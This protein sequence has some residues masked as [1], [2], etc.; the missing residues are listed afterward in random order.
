M[1][2]PNKT[3][4]FLWKQ[5][6]WRIAALVVVLAAGFYFVKGGAKSKQSGT[7]FTARRGALDISVLEGGSV[8]AL[9][10][11]EIKCEV[12]V[13]YQGIKILRIVEEGYQV[14]EDD[15]RTNK[16]LVELDSSELHKQMTQQD[17]TFESTAASLIDAQQAYDIQL[18]QNLSD[19][20]AAEQKAKFARMDF[21][22]FLG[23][24][25][26]QDIIEQ[27]GPLEEQIPDSVTN[28]VDKLAAIA[29]PSPL[30]VA[31][32][33]GKV[34]KKDPPVVLTDARPAVE[35]KLGGGIEGATPPVSEAAG[36]SAPPAAPPL[37]AGTNGN[38][39]PVTNVPPVKI[40]IDFLKYAKVEALGDGEAKQKIRKFDDDLQVAL[41]ELE[42]AKTT[43]DGTRRLEAKGFASKTELGRDEISY[44]NN[45]LKVQTAE[46]ARDLFLK[47]D[48][49]KQAEEFLSKDLEAERELDRARKGAV[50]KLAQAEAKLKSSEGRYNLELRQR[51]EL[52]EQLEKC[53]IAAK[54]PG[55]VVYGA[56]G[57]ESYY[58]GGEERIREG[59]TVRERQ[60]II[61][62]PN[63]TKMAVKVKIHETYIKKVKKGQKVR[64]TVDAFADK[65]LEGEVTKVGVLPDS[66]NRWMNPDLKVYVTTIAIEGVRDWLKPGMS[67]KV[68]ILVDRLPNV[69]YIPIQAVTPIDGKQF[70]Y[71]LKGGGQELREVE[72]GDFNDEF[73]EI[74]KRDPGG[75]KSLPPRARRIRVGPRRQNQEPGERQARRRK[76]QGQTSSRPGSNADQSK[77]LIERRKCQTLRSSSLRMFERLTIW[78]FLWSKRC[79][80]FPPRFIPA[81]LLVSWDHPAAESRPC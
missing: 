48:F 32:D 24:A 25:A 68:E 3:K 38:E 69:V 53:L 49:P 43:L 17:I 46:T 54:K 62:I 29:A 47:Y 23:A 56:G 55:L 71:V 39:K 30:S 13:G 20:K 75:R 78:V 59:A 57:E 34:L 1:Q 76:R 36:L 65:L 44:E 45:R 37:V 64:I 52:Q 42:Q 67:S 63:M 7:T 26:T 2:N 41:K 66:Q 81:S 8:Q 80:E 35:I 11:Q 28:R 6:R 31:S 61:T 5:K 22:K 16:V 74:K 72:A 40:S 79:A 14:T 19:I 33:P 4:A 73:I 58:Y 15:I 10:S 12:K 27:F 21:D 9:E 51:K 77:D 50:S 60:A 18:N 70:C